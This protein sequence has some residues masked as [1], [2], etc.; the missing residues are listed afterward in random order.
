MAAPAAA[1][2]AVGGLEGNKEWMQEEVR[3]VRV[4]P[5]PSLDAAHE[6]LDQGWALPILLQCLA[7]ATRR[8]CSPHAH[9][10][11]PQSSRISSW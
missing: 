10:N 5:A 6:T 4:Q 7:C 2:A 11:S 1:P 9:R 3:G 8:L